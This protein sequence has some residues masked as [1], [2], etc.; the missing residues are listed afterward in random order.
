MTQAVTLEEELKREDW[1]KFNDFFH[2]YDKSMNPVL[3]YIHIT[4]HIGEKYLIDFHDYR[5][6]GIKKAESHFDSYQRITG[7]KMPNGYPDASGKKL[8]FKSEYTIMR[9]GK[10]IEATKEEYDADY[11]LIHEHFARYNKWS[12]NNPEPFKLSYWNF[13]IGTCFEDVRNGSQEYFPIK[14]IVDDDSEEG[15]IREITGL[16]HREFEP[17]LDKDG[18]A[19]VYVWW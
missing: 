16:F 14:E 4:D 8:G 11:K 19:K 3:D 18:G 10:T 7:D 12:K 5:G 13:L 6:L 9:E 17:V 1:G 2:G 15:W